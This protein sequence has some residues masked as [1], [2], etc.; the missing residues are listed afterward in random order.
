[1]ESSIF[2]RRIGFTET[3]IGFPYL[4]CAVTLVQS[5][6]SYL[7]QLFKMLYPAVADRFQTSPACVERDIRTL[8]RAF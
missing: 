1:M 7:Y 8:I 5:D 3:Y 2:L 6:R 4:A